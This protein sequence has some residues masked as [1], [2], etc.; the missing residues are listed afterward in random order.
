MTL[1]EQRSRN[2]HDS[3]ALH[4]CITKWFEEV[5]HRLRTWVRAWAPRQWNAGNRASANRTDGIA[6][7]RSWFL[8]GL[9]TFGPHV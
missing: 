7:A 6:T 3:D 1:I 9:F 5:R 4:A 8:D 2:S